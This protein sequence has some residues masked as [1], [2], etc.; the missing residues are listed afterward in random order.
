MRQGTERQGTEGI[1]NMYPDKNSWHVISVLGNNCRIAIGGPEYCFSAESSFLCLSIQMQKEKYQYHRPNTKRG[2]SN[3]KMLMAM[4]NYNFP[5]EPI[6]WGLNIHL[7][8]MEGAVKS[9][10]GANWGAA[11]WKGQLWLGM[12]NSSTLLKWW[13][14]TEVTSEVKWPQ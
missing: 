12:R 11:G 14:S 10:V 6:H 13:Y 1:G 4:K 3:L 5:C 7:L 8:G 9:A 2:G